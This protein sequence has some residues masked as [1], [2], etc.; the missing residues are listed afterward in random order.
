MA[1]F[2]TVPLKKSYEVDLVKPILNFIGDTYGSQ[3][4]YKRAVAEFAALRKNAVCRTLDKH[5]S[6]LDVLQRYYDQLCSIEAK[7]PINESQ[8]P[9]NFTWKDA[10]DKG[11]LFGSSAKITV[12]RASFEK[13]CVLFNIGAMMSHIAGELTLDSDEGMKT[14]AKYFQQAAGCF[15][16]IKDH[17]MSASSREPTVDLTPD[18]TG[19]LSLIM[20]A[21]AQEVFCLKATA[22]KMKD[23]S[24][25][26][27][28]NQAA[29]NYNDAFKQ[30]QSRENLPKEVLPLLAAKHSIYQAT[31]QVHRATLSKQQKNFGEEVG[32][33]QY[34]AELVKT[35]TSRYDEYISV[36][37]LSDKIGRSLTAAKKDNDFIYHDRVPDVKDL[38]PIGKVTLVKIILPEGRLSSKF[39]DLFEKLVPLAV[40]NAVT[41][42]NQRRADVVNSSVSQ[43]RDASAL[44]N[45]TLASLNLPAALE[46]ISGDSVP[47]SIMEKSQAVI[48]NGGLVKINSLMNNLPES[49]KR[50]REI[51]DEALKVLADEQ[52]SD[53]ELRKKFQQKWQRTPSSELYKCLRTEGDKYGTLISNAVNADKVVQEK[54]DQLQQ[55]IGLL[56]QPESDL[57]AAIPSANPTAALA[58]SEVVQELR[59]LLDQLETIKN[60]R[61]SIESEL[62][63]VEADMT[64]SFLEALAQDG[65]LDEEQLSQQEIERLYGTV[66]QRVGHNIQQQEGLLRQLQL[67]HQ[68]FSQHKQA[69]A[70]SNLREDT[71]KQLATAYDGFMGLRSNLVEGTKFYNDLTEILLKFQSKCND[72]VFARKTERDELLKDIQGNLANAGSAPSMPSI[73]SYQSPENQT[74][75]VPQPLPRSSL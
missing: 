33:L 28:A 70:E 42:F 34:A 20:L 24:I 32:R 7:I 74:K 1:T 14:A 51:L 36:K 64:S 23:A 52:L 9:V 10:F 22:D 29:D 25:A 13:M 31:A 3:E 54:Y 55:P 57:Q 61:E 5:V 4:D 40:N 69:S 6:S 62:R 21:Q 41:A 56:C 35:V 63:S 66:R 30:C 49:F 58:G 59:S 39:S 11:S 45:G 12:P 75:I 48:A 72:I 27:L 38:E 50:N 8:L 53:D 71:L 17:V 15:A 60:E 65:A 2:I 46:D 73:P 19:A 67:K 26:K 44:L 16:H 68:E 43:L 47:T 18:T 37:E